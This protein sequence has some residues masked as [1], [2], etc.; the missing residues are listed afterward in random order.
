MYL[1]VIIK[2]LKL[3]TKWLECPLHVFADLKNS[4]FC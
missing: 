1:K 3:V 2:L 4:W